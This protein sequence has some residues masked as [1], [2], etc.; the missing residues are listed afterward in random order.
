VGHVVR[1]VPSAEAALQAIDEALPAALLL[2]LRLGTG[3]DGWDL[4]AVLRGR[5]ETTHLPVVVI[6]AYDDQARGEAL[7]VEAYLSKPVSRRQLLGAL[8]R[9]QVAPD[10]PVLVVGDDVMTRQLV[11]DA[12]ERSGIPTRPTQST[13]E[14]FALLDASP[15]AYGLLMLDLGSTTLAEFPAWTALIA[16]PT[17]GDLPVVVFT[18]HELSPE[19]MQQL[20]GRAHEVV[21]QS[22]GVRVQDA[23]TRALGLPPQ[24]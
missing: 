15:T 18:D 9:L 11:V 12:L 5:P 24:P 4:L 21:R 3:L 16:R 19:E 8:E 13:A 1:A 20:E 22:D 23:V 17:L 6:S 10:S 2:D 7:G 14:A